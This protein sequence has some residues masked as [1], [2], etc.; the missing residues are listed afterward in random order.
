MKDKKGIKD[1]PYSE[2]EYLIS[3]MNRQTDWGVV[4]CLVGN[5]QAINKGEAGLKEWIESIKRNFNDWDVYMSNTLLSSGDVTEEQITLIE[6]QLKP[7][8]GL[9]LKMSM[10]VLLNQ[11]LLVKY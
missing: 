7:R 2:P 10:L 4:V 9:H 1:F 8:E 5:G 6:S 11:L 3:C